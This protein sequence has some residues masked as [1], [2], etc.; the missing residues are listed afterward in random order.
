ML[1]TDEQSEQEKMLAEEIVAATKPFIGVENVRVELTEDYTGD[2]SLRL[3]FRLRPGLDADEGWV[4]EF[5]EYSTGLVLE[6]LRSGLS[7]FPHTWIEP[8]A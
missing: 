3:V 5:S 2:P 1:T 7:R 6:L 8:A 4:R